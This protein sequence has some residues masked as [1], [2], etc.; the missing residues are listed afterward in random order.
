MARI[1]F[2]PGGALTTQVLPEV[3]AQQRNAASQTYQ[4]SAHRQDVTSR[5]GFEVEE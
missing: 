4:F 5:G 1:Y 2:L 3:K